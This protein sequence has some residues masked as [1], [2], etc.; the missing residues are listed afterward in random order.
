MPVKS[1]SR[2]HLVPKKV[3]N[4]RG[5]LTTV[6][7]NPDTGERFGDAAGKKPLPVPAATAG[8]DGGPGRL[9]GLDQGISELHGYQVTIADALAQ[10]LQRKDRA[11]AVAACGMGKTVIAQE[12]FR[13]D[14]EDNP[15][16]NGIYV[17]VTK[18]IRLTD[19]SSD[20]FDRDGVMGPHR[21]LIIHSESDDFKAARSGKKGADAEAAEAAVISEFLASPST[22]PKV[23]FVTYE[24]AEKLAAVQQ[25]MK[26][27]YN[28]DMTVLDE[29]HSLGGEYKFDPSDRR[30]TA[31]RETDESDSAP[32]GRVPRLLFN[33]VEGGLQ[34]QRRVFLS[35]TPYIR[36]EGSVAFG[37]TRARRERQKVPWVYDV[38]EERLRERAALE[39]GTGNKK[40][41]KEVVYL[42]QMNETVFGRTV[43]QYD[44]N[45]AVKQ[46]KTLTEV[47]R[48]VARVRS[49]VPYTPGG[50]RWNFDTLQLN[51]DGAP[52]TTGGMRAPTYAALA[53]TAETLAEGK[54][55]NV[56]TF[57]PLN[58]TTEE[59]RNRF[60]EVTRRL[61]G[62]DAPDS[63]TA[64]DIV[65]APEQHPE[66]R[67]RQA[68]LVLVAEHAKVVHAHSGQSQ[69]QRDEAFHHFDDDRL[70]E[71]T[72]GGQASGRWCACARVVSNF[73]LFGQGIDIKPIDTVVQMNKN[74]LSD[75]AS[76]QTIGRAAR[77]HPTKTSARTVLPMLTFDT[78]EDAGPDTVLNAEMATKTL[79]AWSRLGR[80]VTKWALR[81]E[82]MDHTDE[83]PVRF[84][85]SKQPAG[86]TTDVYRQM[87]GKP[88]ESYI[89]ARAYSEVEGGAK[90]RYRVEVGARDDTKWTALTEDER[91][92]RCED[93]AAGSTN[94]FVK[95]LRASRYPDWD[96]ETANL[97]RRR[98][99]GIDERLRGHDADSL[100]PMERH[101]LYADNRINEQAQPEHGRKGYDA[102]KREWVLSFY[103][104]QTREAL[105]N[106]G[107][108][109][110]TIPLNEAT[111]KAQL[112]QSALNRDVIFKRPLRDE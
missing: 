12:M 30:T 103:A 86:N 63:A 1:P 28:A 7:V 58:E 109:E 95:A 81:G 101:L 49:R 79:N 32:K 73:D 17:F 11:S 51:A 10:E 82:Q 16:T 47:E 39:D 45:Y 55:H 48:T 85:G 50:A 90:A 64:R 84:I 2:S 31:D 57:L 18:S 41:A 56:L 54:A 74:R 71:C 4:A 29:A 87:S 33:G 108:P 34:S 100:T 60:G 98:W 75:S 13:R 40:A 69:A 6:Y 24:S 104:D 76:T 70:T 26:G 92:R 59:Y 8:A 105:R 52:V 42:E 27:D 88:M 110:D 107:A 53:A 91:Q 93:Y 61:A 35:A 72:C 77:K 94:G 66:A 22:E 112:K 89:I 96:S 97:F 15:D 9:Q 23:I 19:Q 67:V 111:H 65:D 44:I 25:A 46:A 3:R 102:S 78:D 5:V 62:P 38:T 80:N 83:T 21:S 20:A 99:D 37:E 14:F 68:R 36:D 43:A 106:L